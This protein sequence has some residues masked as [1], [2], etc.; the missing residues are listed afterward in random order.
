MGRGHSIA[1]PHMQ[2]AGESVTTERYSTLAVTL[3]WVMAVLL[4][5]MLA[6]GFYM[7][8]LRKGTPEVAYYYSLH[9][10][11]GLVALM[12]VAVRLWW[13]ASTATPSY[14]KLQVSPIQEKLACVA[15]RLLYACMTL[16][17]LS[18]FV[19]SNFGKHPV[20][21]FGYALPQ[22]GWDNPAMQVFFRTV[23]AAFVWLLCVLVV[24]H[25]LAVVY[26]LSR[27]GRV[28]FLRILPRR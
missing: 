15:H 9:K 16:I 27:S 21:F 11:L 5:A 7:V 26:H 10:S 18:G 8:G 2:T 17:P 3:H 14:A 28:I 4:L 19:G 13:R 23:H 6:I 20:K 1:I 24:L 12:L 25:V 22:L